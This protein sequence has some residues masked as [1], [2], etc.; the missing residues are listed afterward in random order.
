M[1]L[2]IILKILSLCLLADIL[3]IAGELLIRVAPKFKREFLEICDNPVGG[4]YVL[5]YSFVFFPGLT[6]KFIIDRQEENKTN[7]EIKVFVH[8]RELTGWRK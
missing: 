8:G 2:Y 5:R 4:I 3:F 7:I 6:L 1:I